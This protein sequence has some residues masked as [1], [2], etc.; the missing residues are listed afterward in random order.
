MSNVL[1]IAA[2]S[3]LGAQATR[4]ECWRHDLQ[5]VPQ[6]TADLIDCSSLARCQSTAS[7]GA[8]KRSRSFNS[9]FSGIGSRRLWRPVLL[10]LSA[11]QSFMRQ[12]V[13]YSQ[14]AA[15]LITSLSINM[16]GVRYR[17]WCVHAM[18]MQNMKAGGLESAAALC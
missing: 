16:D 18:E 10:P 6:D 3:H 8:L 12:T 17:T 2:A 15:R 13:T 5:G 11:L 14:I 9:S 4:P 7:T 1:S